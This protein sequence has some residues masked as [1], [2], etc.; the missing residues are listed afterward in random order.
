MNIVIIEDEQHTANDL[1]QTILKVV[2]NAKIID[3]LKS[4]TESIHFFKS[5]KTKIDLIFSDIQLGDGLSFEIFNK[6]QVN[7]PIIFCTAYDEYALNAFKVNGI[8]YMLK[9]FTTKTVEMA[10]AKYRE[11]KQNFS[12]ASPQY[13]TILKLLEGK[14]TPTSVLVYKNDKILPVRIKDIALFYIE[15]EITRIITFEQKKFS[16]NK[17]IE[18]LETIAGETFYRANRQFLV[19]RAAIKDTS[20]YFARKL[21]INL[22]FHFDQK[23]TVSK[24]KVAEF[25][26]WLASS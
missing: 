17:S 24:N 7:T 23:I 14:K 9:P 13:E 10:I 15:N 18:E 5:N 25:L 26:K 16:I 2:P 1:E 12:Q 3:I 6:L 4:V 8:H 21:S 22:T 19:N 11:L 20:Q